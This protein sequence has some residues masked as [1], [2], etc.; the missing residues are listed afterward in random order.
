MIIN[1]IFYACTMKRLSFFLLLV[2]ITMACGTQP[3]NKPTLIDE[4]YEPSDEELFAAC[5][6]LK[7]IG[8]YVIGKSTFS[9]ITKDK[10]YRS[11]VS[12]D[13][14]KSNLYNGHWGNS[15]WR[16]PFG[17]VS[18]S[19]QARYIEK[20]TKGK[21][22]QLSVRPSFKVGE[23]EFD[24]FDLAFLNDTL[25]AIWYYPKDENTVIN[26]YL[27]KYGNGKG[28]KYHFETRTKDIKGDV[29]GTERHDELHVW[30]NET[31]A[32]EYINTVNFSHLPN[33]KIHY[34]GKKTMLLYSKSRYPVFEQILKEYAKKFEDS[35]GVAKE[36][37]LSTL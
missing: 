6:D 2:L 24:P 19:E 29:Y 20:E 28:K 34:D 7:G 26:H 4:K 30:A 36:E 14:N 32:L 9:S 33:Q 3:E 10:E 22:K 37:T 18:E 8:Q 13:Y 31:V 27:E 5:S 15:F 23:L 11:Q 12:Y 1:R 16:N 17:K 21:V 25:V 35:K